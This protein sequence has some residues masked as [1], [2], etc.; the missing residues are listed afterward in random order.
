MLHL[1]CPENLTRVGGIRTGGAEAVCIDMD[2]RLGR[3]AVGDID[4]ALRLFEQSVVKEA[5]I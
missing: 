5:G 3:V 1:W 4:G 2:D